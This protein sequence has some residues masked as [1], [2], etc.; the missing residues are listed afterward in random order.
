MCKSL[1]F[2]T[3]RPHVA[4]NAGTSWLCEVAFFLYLSPDIACLAAYLALVLHSAKK[5]TLR[6]RN[7]MA[8][9][10]AFLTLMA[11]AAPMVHAGQTD[12]IEALGSTNGTLQSN[13]EHTSSTALELTRRW[14][15]R[16]HTGS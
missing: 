11:C 12:L 4:P 14:A 15:S 7:D 16:C 9:L 8:G 2:S 6:N 5:D 10:Y 13:T 1:P 3:G